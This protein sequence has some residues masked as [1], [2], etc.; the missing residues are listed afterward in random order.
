[1]TTTVRMRDIAD[2]DRERL[3]EWRNSPAV[4]AYMYSDHLISRE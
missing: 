4:S 3:L 2:E 1:M